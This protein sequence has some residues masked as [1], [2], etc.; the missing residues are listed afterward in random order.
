MSRGAWR[1]A[2]DTRCTVRFSICMAAFGITERFAHRQIFPCAVSNGLLLTHC[3]PGHHVASRWRD[4]AAPKHSMT[5]SA[6]EATVKP[7][8]SCTLR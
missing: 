5:Y 1:M 8:A 3:H 2:S 7:D 4:A 6:E